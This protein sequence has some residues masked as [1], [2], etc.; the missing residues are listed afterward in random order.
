MVIGVDADGIVMPVGLWNPSWRFPWWFFLLLIPFVFISKPRKKTVEELRNIQKEG[1]VIIIVSA[2]PKQVKWLTE[3]HFR[4]HKVP[5]KKV[6]CVG[7]GKGTKERKL[8]AARNE[9]VVI[10]VDDN[11]R[12]VSANCIIPTNQN[13]NNIQK[14]METLVP[15]ILSKPENEIKLTLE[16]LV[17]AYDPCISCSTHALNITI[18]K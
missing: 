4:V 2:R 14:D 9:N 16:M 5:F 15:L 11:G 7:P 17:R 10:F 6:I 12:I 8:E 13:H 3:T 18:K 1:G